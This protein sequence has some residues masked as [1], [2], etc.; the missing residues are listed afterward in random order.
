MTSFSVFFKIIPSRFALGHYLEEHLKV[1][2][3]PTHIA[4]CKSLFLSKQAEAWLAAVNQ[5]P[6]LRFYALFKTMFKPEK[7][8]EMSLSS[9]ERS[10]LAQI[11]F[12]ILKLEVETGRYNSTKLED[13]LCKICNQNI[14]EDEN[15]FLF[16]CNAYDAL[17]N[18]WIETIYKDCPDFHYLEDEDQLKY[19]FEKIPRST[20]KFIISC[21]NVRNDILYM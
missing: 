20:A 12:G 18:S 14:V 19:I 9:H 2:H 1:G 16:H 5:K 17:R 7:Y 21:L 13:R 3:Y 8:V 15:H 6:K 4:S 10:V 11:R